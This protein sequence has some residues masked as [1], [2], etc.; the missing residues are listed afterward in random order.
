M[1]YQIYSLALLIVMLLTAACQDNRIYSE[2]AAYQPEVQPQLGLWRGVLTLQGKEAPFQFEIQEPRPDNYVVYLI[3]GKE[4]LKLDEV[5]KKADSLIISLHTFDAVLATK[6][7]NNKQLEGKWIKYGYPEPYEVPFKAD[8]GQNYRFESSKTAPKKDFS[9]KWAVT[10]QEKDG[11]TYPAI[12]IFSQ[13]DDLVTGTFLT[14]TGDYRFLEG[15]VANDTLQLTAFDG[16]HGFLFK[17]TLEGK[18]LSGSFWSGNHSL[19]TFKGYR[20][21]NAKLPDANELTFLK[22]GYDEVSF[23]FPDIKG[24]TLRFP[25]EAYKGKVVLV[26]IMG[27]WCSN[28]MDETNFYLPFYKKNKNKGFEIIALAYERSPDFDEAA[29]RVKKMIAKY[30]IEY[31]VLVA[32]T[33][34]KAATS[35]TLPMLNKIISYP[36]TIFIDRKGKVRRIHTGFS[37]PGT[38]AYYEKFTNEF[39]Q[40]MEKLLSE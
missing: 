8:F 3:N 12:G 32:G 24:D 38:G 9:G 25:S 36:T 29:K 30:G 17:A 7:I 13:K 10:F 39:Y 23:A 31:P 14:T 26:Q 34:D 35:E 22:E 27:T 16:G 5:S 18:L 20:D 40:F 33:N 15:N 4:R 2:R 28:C 1:K 6:I 37:G 11:A 21:E 19:E